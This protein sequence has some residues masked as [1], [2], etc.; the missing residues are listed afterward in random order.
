MSGVKGMRA[1]L[2][3]GLFLPKQT[4]KKSSLF[5]FLPCL[6]FL[7]LPG[8]G[9]TGGGSSIKCR[10]SASILPTCPIPEMVRGCIMH[11][12]KTARKFMVH[13][14]LGLRELAGSPHDVWG[15]CISLTRFLFTSVLSCLGDLTQRK[16]QPSHLVV[17]D[18]DPW[19]IS[20][21]NNE[22]DKK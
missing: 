20:F 14:C 18:T 19:K 17:W 13:L 7:L 12:G 5:F 21:L 8:P 15:D 2:L 1:R 16:T 6:T 22:K 4:N 11:L 3:F 9:I 10:A